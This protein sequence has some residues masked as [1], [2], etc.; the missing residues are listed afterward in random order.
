MSHSSASGGSTSGGDERSTHEDETARYPTDESYRHG[1]EPVGDDH[2]GD[3]ERYAEPQHYGDHQH[4]GEHERRPGGDS[5]SSYDEGYAAGQRDSR[6]DAEHHHAAPPVEVVQARRREEF[7]GFN[8]G[9]AFFGW[10]VAIALTVLLAGIVGAIAAGVGSTVE[11]S[12]S[13]AE[14]EAGTIGIATGIALLVVLMIAYFAGGYVAGRMSR[15]DGG[16][17]GIGV[18]VIGVIVTLLVALLG[19]LFGAEYNIFDRVSLPSIPVPTDNLTTGG[20]IAIA[21]IVVGSLLAAIL[22]GKVGERYH[23]KV[24]RV[25]V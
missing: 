14:R 21:A 13:E 2:D 8:L 23:K 12:Q 4:Y 24:D 9:A 25:T 1:A 17:Q 16:R 3:Q 22:G 6:A 10:L 11:V 5:A 15:F 18:W 7:G 20:I 19:A